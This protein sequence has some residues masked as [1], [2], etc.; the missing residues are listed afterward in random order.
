VGKCYA[1][2][3]TGQC[4]GEQTRHKSVDKNEIWRVRGQY[5]RMHKVCFVMI[6]ADHRSVDWVLCG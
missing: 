1:C 4:K 5:I 2:G 3:L 6:L